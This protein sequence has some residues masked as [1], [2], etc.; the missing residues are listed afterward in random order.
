MQPE[1]G[2]ITKWCFSGVELSRARGSASWSYP[3]PRPG[4]LQSSGL[5][6][7]PHLCLGGRA[8]WQCHALEAQVSPAGAGQGS[9]VPNRAPKYCTP[10]GGKALPPDAQ[11][12]TLGRL[13]ASWESLTRKTTFARVRRLPHTTS[14]PDLCPPRR[15]CSTAG[16]VVEDGRGSGLAER[17]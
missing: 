12:Y 6:A 5:R 7:C 11:V 2:N 3:C 8:R 4:A 10:S 17:Q 1:C 13:R 15:V 9:F 14:F 16:I